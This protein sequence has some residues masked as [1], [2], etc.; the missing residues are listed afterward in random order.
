MALPDY[1]IHSICSERKWPASS[2]GGLAAD[3]SPRPAG[4]LER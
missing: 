4:C 1:F 3:P 2:E